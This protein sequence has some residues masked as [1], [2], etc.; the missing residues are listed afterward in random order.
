MQ[1]LCKIAL[2]T[3]WLP[4]LMG[5]E[6]VYRWVDEDGVVNYTQHLPWGVKA[7]QITT[8]D[9]APSVIKDVTQA[10]EST[11][12]ETPPLTSEQQAMLDELKAAELVRQQEA[13]KI[14]VANCE[15]A[16]EVLSKLSLSSRI[17]VRDPSGNERVM[18][19]DERQRRIAEA[20]QGIVVNCSATRAG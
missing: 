10:I 6:L 16:Q 1:T 15:K 11:A 5:A 7:Q 18:G 14:R 19:E 20:Q 9:G 17:R 4:M 12:R 8:R 2:L 13:A 3:L